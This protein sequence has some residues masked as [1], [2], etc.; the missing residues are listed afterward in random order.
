M[1]TQDSLPCSQEP[2]NGS[3]PKP[4]KYNPHPHPISL[5]I[6]L[7]LSFYAF[8]IFPQTYQHILMFVQVQNT[9]RIF[10]HTTFQNGFWFQNTHLA[11][12]FDTVNLREAKP[13]SEISRTEFVVNLWLL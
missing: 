12:T 1:G 9:I 5:R 3:Y 8:K 2:T 4:N 10:H 6:I 11:T 7:L 13:Y